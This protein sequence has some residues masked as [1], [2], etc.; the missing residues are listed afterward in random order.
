MGVD[1]CNGTSRDDLVVPDDPNMVPIK[2][3][4]IVSNASMQTN[5]A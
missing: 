1:C 5:K 3:S 2:K 4:T